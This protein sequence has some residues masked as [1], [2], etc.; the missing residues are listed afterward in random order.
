M[1]NNALL[2]ECRKNKGLTQ[3]DASK[4]IG[5]ARTTYADYENGKI[6]PPIDKIHR[7][8]EWLD[9]PLE[10]IMHIENNTGIQL[11]KFKTKNRMT[12]AEKIQTINRI[13][14]KADTLNTFDDIAMIVRK[15]NIEVQEKEI[16][17]NILEY[18]MQKYIITSSDLELYKRIQKAVEND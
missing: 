12:D 2:K 11:S 9:L 3:Y 8:C 15:M 5:V 18:I 10:K 16:V 6:Q 14:K 7:I 17:L 4:I 1:F 13:K